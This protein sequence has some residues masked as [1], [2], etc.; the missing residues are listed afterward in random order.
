[1][2]RQITR[3]KKASVPTSAGTLHPCKANAIK[4]VVFRVILVQAPLDQARQA[5]LLALTSAENG[6][7][8]ATHAP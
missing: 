2:C 4:S 5:A 1:V 7:L 3:G 8:L 6:F